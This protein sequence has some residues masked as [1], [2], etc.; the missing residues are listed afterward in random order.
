MATHFRDNASPDTAAD[1]CDAIAAGLDS[2]PVTKHLAPLWDAIAAEGDKL[3]AARRTRQ[4]ALGRARARL[5]VKDMFWDDEAGAFGRELF[6]E[7][8]GKR[9][10]A[11]YTRFFSQTTPSEAKDFGVDREVQLGRGWVKELGRESNAP[12]AVKWTPRLQG[13]TEDL[14]QASKG[15]TS[16]LSEVALH[17][18]AERLYIESVNLELDKLEG[19]LKKL[20]PGEAKR[21]AS[22]LAPTRTRRRRG[23]GDGGEEP[24]GEGENS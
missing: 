18:T 10:K 9:D 17:T 13:V 24:S 21:V 15:R 22:F 20:F 23:Q 3:A 6:N 16:A 7:S 8:G 1:V 14:D 5:V 12:L 19:E 4:R 11:P 2:H